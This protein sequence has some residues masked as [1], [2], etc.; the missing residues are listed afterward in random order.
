[1]AVV[2]STS[3]NGVGAVTPASI[4][5]AT[6]GDTLV[7]VPGQG[8]ELYLYNTSASPVV[9]TVDGSAGTTVAVAGAA[10]ATLNV[11]AGLAI[12]VPANSFSQLSLDKAAVYLTGTVAI[13]AATGAVV[14]AAIVSQY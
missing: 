11:A 2:A 6:S 3:K 8:D 1:M 12:T 5:L 10:G 13:T 4:A 9:V 7:Y 14:K